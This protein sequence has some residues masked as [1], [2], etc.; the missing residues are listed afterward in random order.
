MPGFFTAVSL[1]RTWYLGLLIMGGTPFSSWAGSEEAGMLWQTNTP[2]MGTLFSIKVYAE[3]EEQAST[4]CSAAF[5]EARELE[6]ILSARRAESELSRLNKTPANTPFPAGKTLFHALETALHY[7]SLTNGAFDPTLGSCM[8]LW[9]RTLA[10]KTLPTPEQLAQT[11]NSCGF[12]Q[13]EVNP[14]SIIKRAEGMKLDLGGIGKGMAVDAMAQCLKSAGLSRFCISSTSDVLAGDPPP[15]KTCWKVC[16]DEHS[17]EFISLVNAAVSTSG[18]KNQF[19]VIDG[20]RYS[21]IL[22]PVTG[23]GLEDGRTVTVRAQNASEADAL[24]T[25]FCVLPRAS[26]PA[27]LARFPQA[28]ILHI[29]ENRQPDSTP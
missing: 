10:R 5:E 7:A 1:C 27:V 29:T 12:T 3:S 11:R 20:K 24:A 21:H 22:D 8:H 19:V 17:G 14:K 28:S 16:L 15:G 18:D 6:A 13:L 23:L 26:F 2:L 4:A 9:R 25:A